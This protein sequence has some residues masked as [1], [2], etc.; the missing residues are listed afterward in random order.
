MKPFPHLDI[1]FWKSEVPNRVFSSPLL[2]IPFLTGTSQTACTNPKS[3]A[4]R[5]ACGRSGGVLGRT[6]QLLSGGGGWSQVS[7]GRCKGKSQ[8]NPLLQLRQQTGTLLF[9]IYAYCANS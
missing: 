2:T 8:T 6:S 7:S 5:C 4:V 1:L 3:P 9:K